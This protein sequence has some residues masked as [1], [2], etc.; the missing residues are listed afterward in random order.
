M[1][2]KNK[3]LPANF[4]NYINPETALLARGPVVDLLSKE[5]NALLLGCYKSVI[6]QCVTTIKAE[7]FLNCGKLEHIA[8]PNSVCEIENL[9]FAGC[10]NLQA[11]DIPDSVFRAG[12]I[13]MYCQSLKA[14]RIGRGLTEVRLKLTDYSV[15]GGPDA[16]NN[17]EEIVVSCDNPYYYSDGNCLIEKSTGTIVL[18]CKNSIIPASAKEIGCEAFSCIKTDEI[19][20]PFGIEVVQYAAFAGSTIRR[21]ILPNSVKIIEDKVFSRCNCLQLVELP[22]SIDFKEYSPYIFHQATV[23]ML[24]VPR[25]SGLY[26]DIGVNYHAYFK[27]RYGDIFAR[28]SDGTLTPPPYFEK[29]KETAS[30][31]IKSI[32]Q[33]ISLTDV[34]DEQERDIRKQI[35]NLIKHNYPRYSKMFEVDETF[36]ITQKAYL[37]I[38]TILNESTCLEDFYKKMNL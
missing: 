18:G 32:V 9:A 27:I 36:V 3:L 17:L 23:N 31:I 20:I 8:I 22:E 1:F 29:M 28:E 12:D 10:Y 7:A 5:D 30:S 21:C 13:L 11:F 35:N 34:F 25:N 19:V 33:N 24:I 2:L 26:G 16:Y 6:P 15:F 14:L 4:G 38:L 37:Y